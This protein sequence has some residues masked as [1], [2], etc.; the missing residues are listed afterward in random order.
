MP[1]KVTSAFGTTLASSL[2]HI[3]KSCFNGCIAQIMV[4]AQA[5][6]E[7][8]VARIEVIVAKARDREERQIAREKRQLLK[9]GKEKLEKRK[10][11][12]LEK[13]GG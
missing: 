9:V 8:Q 12:E 5:R 11:P 10:F 1:C 4:D 6:E 7:R 13:K 2:T 3:V